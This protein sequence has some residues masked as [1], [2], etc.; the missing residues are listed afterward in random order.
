MKAVDAGVKRHRSFGQNAAVVA[1]EDSS[2]WRWQS[3]N[4]RDSFRTGFP[5]VGPDLNEVGGHERR[6][7]HSRDVHRPPSVINFKAIKRCLP[8]GVASICGI[9]QDIT[10]EI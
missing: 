2:A 3:D 4:T 10:V 8:C 6:K 5:Y 9:V 1:I 7:R